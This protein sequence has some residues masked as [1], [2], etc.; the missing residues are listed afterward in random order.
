M[1]DKN[2]QTFEQYTDNKFKKLNISG[3]IKFIR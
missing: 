1:K 2:I 3:V